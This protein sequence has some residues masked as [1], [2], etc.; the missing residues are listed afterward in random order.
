[1]AALQSHLNAPNP[2]VFHLDVTLKQ[3]PL[4]VHGRPEQLV[5]QQ[6]RGGEPR[7]DLL[8]GLVA[9]LAGLSEVGRRAAWKQ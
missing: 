6:P 3:R 7:P 4:G 5:E 9:L 8:C 1:V 2:G